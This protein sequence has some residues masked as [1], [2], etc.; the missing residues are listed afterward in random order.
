MEKSPGKMNVQTNTDLSNSNDSEAESSS[1]STK[2]SCTSVMSSLDLG[3]KN[4]FIVGDIFMRK[5]YTVF[6]RDNDRVG[7]A[8]AVTADEIKKREKQK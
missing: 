1:T 2:D 4:T 6:D 3:N 8:L 5:F 7:I